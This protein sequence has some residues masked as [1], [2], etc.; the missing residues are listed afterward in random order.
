MT[1][2]SQSLFYLVNSSEDSTYDMM[3]RLKL[4]SVKKTGPISS[5]LVARKKNKSL[6]PAEL[7]G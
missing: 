2:I 6:L 3:R 7:H 1:V 5:F 4:A